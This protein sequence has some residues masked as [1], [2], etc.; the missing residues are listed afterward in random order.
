MLKMCRAIKALRMRSRVNQAYA[1]NVLRFD[2][3]AGGKITFEFGGKHLHD[4]TLHGYPGTAAN[5]PHH[6]PCNPCL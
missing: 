1:R 2:N 3:S 6:G 4:V 5:M